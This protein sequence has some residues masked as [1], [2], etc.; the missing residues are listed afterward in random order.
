MKT[1]PQCN[2]VFDDSLD[3]CTED[4]TPLAQET[5]V[6]PSEVTPLDAEE[7]TVVRGEPITIDIPNQNAPAPT[8]QFN[9]QAP[10]V[11]TVVIEKRRNM[12]KYVLFMVLGLVLG[13]SLVLAAVLFSMYFFQNK[14]PANT[15][16]RNSQINSTTT[17]KPTTTTTPITA[18]AKHE[19]RTDADDDEFNGR[20]ITLNAYMRSSPSRSAQ[21]IDV[22]P[23]DDRLHIEERENENSPWYRVTCEHGTAGWM[24]G[25]TIEYRR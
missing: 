16:N 7:E 10:A 1:C 23:I 24:H 25:N 3:Y 4:G 11:E 9:Y 15:V 21:E 17:P 20:V 2:R 5:F 14:P 18:S 8:E 19:K 22:L 12:S 6:L 13:G